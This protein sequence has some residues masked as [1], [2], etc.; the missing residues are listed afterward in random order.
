[1][2]SPPPP[3]RLREEERAKRDV[4]KLASECLHAGR[5]DD[6]LSVTRDV[7][8]W[9]TNVASSTSSS[10]SAFV[11]DDDDDEKKTEDGKEEKR[12]RDK[13]I[14]AFFVC[15]NVARARAHLCLRQFEECLTACNEILR[16]TPHLAI[17]NWLKAKALIGLGGVY[18]A[19]I[20]LYK[21]RRSLSVV[22]TGN[23]TNEKKKSTRN[24][25]DEL[26][27]EIKAIEEMCKQ[28]LPDDPELRVEKNGST[29]HNNKRCSKKNLVVGKK[30]EKKEKEEEEEG[31]EIYLND[32][33][34]DDTA[35]EY[36]KKSAEKKSFAM[37]WADEV[38]QE[39]NEEE[40]QEK[41]QSK[42][43]DNQFN[44]FI[45]M[46]SFVHLAIEN[47][48]AKRDCL[49]SLKKYGQVRVAMPNEAFDIS[50][51]DTLAKVIECFESEYYEN[52]D[53]EFFAP[54]WELDV[55]NEEPTEVKEVVAVEK[56]N[57]E[58]EHETNGNLSYANIA[59]KNVR[60]RSN[61]FDVTDSKMNKELF[62]PLVSDSEP[63]REWNEPPLEEDFA[64]RPARRRE[65]DF[66]TES[67]G[68]AVADA[69]QIL[70]MVAIRV[71][72][73]ILRHSFPDIQEE[74]RHLYSVFSNLEGPSEEFLESQRTRKNARESFVLRAQS[75]TLIGRDD[76][77]ERTRAITDKDHFDQNLFLTCEWIYDASLTSPTLGDTLE[78]RRH[79]TTTPS[80]KT[81][82]T[83]N[84]E[85]DGPIIHFTVGP[86]LRKKYSS[87]LLA[88]P[89]TT[90]FITTTSSKKT[91]QHHDAQRRQKKKIVLP[92]RPPRVVRFSLRDEDKLNC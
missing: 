16:A 24:E 66:P 78:R 30:N 48:D 56:E 28:A 26:E 89:T 27:V 49:D 87:T 32:K 45:P 85:L 57:F 39:D 90:S 52:D 53:V 14:D 11:R 65:T 81:F 38:E 50:I 61:A 60:T 47:D 42:V 23:G 12:K 13:K 10:K 46:V 40:E 88:N 80:S 55:E 36:E 83:S 37:S 35:D 22:A 59:K 77:S 92:S 25:N 67:F 20:Y 64:P 44:A 6:A 84:V 76:D 58:K 79:L 5:F 75:G 73:S 43:E 63:T 69:T 1:M 17:A 34:M 31:E 18:E 82:F 19:R 68:T 29:H 54:A 2:T 91:Q 41:I 15:A 33:K 70:E 7:S 4:L 71:V 8:C 9:N 86:A 51:G 74:K 72:T 21:C 62:P 3:P